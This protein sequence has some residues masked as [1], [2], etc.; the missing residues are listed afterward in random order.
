MKIPDWEVQNK[1]IAG[2]SDVFATL[3]CDCVDR[4]NNIQV[5][6][7]SIVKDKQLNYGDYV[8]SLDELSS[9]L[10]VVRERAVELV[11]MLAFVEEMLPVKECYCCSCYP[12]ILSIKR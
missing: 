9:L 6:E 11:L 10:P 4:V 8:L 12:D 5:H 7:T 2:T 1:C 3:D